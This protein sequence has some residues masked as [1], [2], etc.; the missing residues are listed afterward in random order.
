M[1]SEYAGDP[2]DAVWLLG[3]ALDDAP[4][5]SSGLAHP[6]RSV[7]GNRKELGHES[8]EFVINYTSDLWHVAYE[9][10]HG[11]LD[12]RTPAEVSNDSTRILA[13]YMPMAILRR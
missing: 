7:D 3:G 2:V 9:R 1:A 13:S 12:M 10:L 5:P 6:F 8:I 4:S 11:E